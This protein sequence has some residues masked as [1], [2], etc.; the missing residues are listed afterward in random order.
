NADIRGKMGAMRSLIDQENY[1]VGVDKLKKTSVVLEN[2]MG[3]VYEYTWIIG[4]P[5][6][7]K[8]T[9]VELKESFTKAI[10]HVS[11]KVVKG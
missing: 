1:A 4:V 7:K 3:M 9:A 6:L 10:D 8:D 2:E 5:L 11:E